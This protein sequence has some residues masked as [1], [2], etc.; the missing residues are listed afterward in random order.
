MTALVV[1]EPWATMIVTGEK[2]IELRTTRTKKIGQEIY[3]AKAGTKTLIGKVT[4]E[5]CCPLTKEECHLFVDK[6][7]AE[8]IYP[9]RQIYGWFLINPILFEK[10]IP[11]IHPRG[12]QSW[13][14]LNSQTFCIN[15]A[16]TIPNKVPATN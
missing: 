16:P 9:H 15:Q 14:K 3:I 8:G 4:I 6:H 5:K 10:S 11:Y 7:K 2:T 13:V 1:K 12:A